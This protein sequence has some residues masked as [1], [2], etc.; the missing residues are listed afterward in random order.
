MIPEVGIRG[1]FS[2]LEVPSFDEDF[3]ELYCVA[4]ENNQFIIKKVEK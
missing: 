1:T 4:I 2:K 3:D